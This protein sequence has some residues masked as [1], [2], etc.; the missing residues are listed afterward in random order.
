VLKGRMMPSRVVRE[1][2]LDSQRYWSVTIEARQLFWHLMLLADDLGCVSLAPAFVRRRCFDDGPAPDRVNLLLGQLSDADLV[3]MYEADGARYGFIP[4]F[5]Q[6]LKRMTLRHP[7]PPVSLIE[8]DQEAREKFKR[9]KTE[10]KKPAASLP[11]HGSQAAALRRP[12]VEV[13]VEGKSTTAEKA[14]AK[15]RD[16]EPSAVF[17]QAWN[18]YPK[19]LGDNPRARAWKAWRG[20]L[21]EGYTEDEMLQGTRRYAAFVRA[22][23]REGTEFVKQAATFFGPDKG[24]IEAWVSPNQAHTGARDAEGKLR[25][26]I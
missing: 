23:G 4:R 12:E 24:F 16:S 11:P 15:K 25:V 1:G 6:R 22:M 13:E 2:L 20:R 26:A 18:E 8:D 10:S 21:A 9:I 19:R 17:L 3:R 7:E 14:P 5:A